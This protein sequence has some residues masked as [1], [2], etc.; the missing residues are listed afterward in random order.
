MATDSEA[1]GSSWISFKPDVFT[2][3]S[4]G[5]LPRTEVICCCGQGEKV[6]DVY[7]APDIDYGTEEK[8][9]RFLIPYLRYSSFN[10][11]ISQKNAFLQPDPTDPTRTSP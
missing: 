4:P 6:I 3:E 7:L 11:I 5:S 2:L 8:T 1:D 9:E 10:I